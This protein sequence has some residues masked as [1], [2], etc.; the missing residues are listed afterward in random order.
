MEEPDQM[1]LLEQ[2]E[3]SVFQVQQEDLVPV[4][5]MDPLAGK[6][7]TEALAL[8]EDRGLPEDQDLL[9]LLEE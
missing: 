5:Q 9:D 3:Q 4:D 2:V 6:D 8:E 7:P 1:E